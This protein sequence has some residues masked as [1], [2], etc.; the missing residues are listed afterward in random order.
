MADLVEKYE[1]GNKVLK[2]FYDFDPENPREWDN[3]GKMVCWHSRYNLGDDHNYSAPEDFLFDLLEE[4][5]GDTDRAERL[6]E[7]ISNS[8]DR[9]AYRS[10]GAYR[11]AV[12]DEI[13]EI[14]GR[15]FIVMPLYMYDHSG[16]TIS[17]SPFSCPW[18][19]GQVGWVFV[20]K[21]KARVEYGVKRISQKLREKVVGVILAEVETYDQYLRG[22]VY[23]YELYDVDSARL[24]DYLKSEGLDRE[25]LNEDDLERFLTQEDSCWGFYGYDLKN[26]GILDHVGQEWKTQLM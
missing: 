10:Y 11:K 26:N 17:T 7:K 16:I 3:L 24:N 14:I 21:E 15:K 20:S 23:G 1:K 22:E 18:D 12:D 8:I 2:V 19:S 13:F 25:D 9:E 4:T 6:I 5:V